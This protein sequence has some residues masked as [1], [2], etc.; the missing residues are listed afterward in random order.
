MNQIL[1]KYNINN[2]N[3]GIMK[4]Q[5][6]NTEA[7]VV[8]TLLAKEYGENKGIMNRKIWTVIGVNYETLDIVTYNYFLTK[9]EARNYC[10]K[11]NLIIYKCIDTTK[12][13]TIFS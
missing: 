6:K 4:N 10:I 11:N 2:K 9:A 13:E 7:Q 8:K 12:D 5:A 1:I 3:K